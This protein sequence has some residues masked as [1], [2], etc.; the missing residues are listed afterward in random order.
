MTVWEVE[1]GKPESPR[2][3]SPREVKGTLELS[4]Q[5]LIFTPRDEA[6]PTV[7]IPLGEIAKV[8]RLRGS[9]VLIVFRE[10]VAGPERTAFYFVQPPPMIPPRGEPLERGR[11]LSTFR[12]PRRQ[13]RRD[14]M[15]Y[16]GLMNRENKVT[17]KEWVRAVDAAVARARD[18]AT[19]SVEGGAES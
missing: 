1:L 11:G 10:T 13:A 4:H 15:S 18:G 6:L 2:P 7:T 3:E 19:G 5:H 12:N 16:L 8:K 9:P 17:L 14:N